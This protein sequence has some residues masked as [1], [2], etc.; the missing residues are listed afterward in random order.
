MPWLQTCLIKGRFNLYVP[1]YLT[2]NN[3][4]AAMEIGRIAW[5]HLDIKVR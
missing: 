5:K 2:K 1:V 3:L 4:I